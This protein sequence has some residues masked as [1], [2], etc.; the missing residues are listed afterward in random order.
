MALTRNESDESGIRRL[1]DVEFSR[2]IFVRNLRLVMSESPHSISGLLSLLIG[3]AM[4]GSNEPWLR[5]G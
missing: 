2:K 1:T 4:V 5:G 3:L